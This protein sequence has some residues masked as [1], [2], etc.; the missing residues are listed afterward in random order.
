MLANAT[1]LRRAG[2]LL[3]A[4]AGSAGWT[5]GVFVDA[6]KVAKDAAIGASD[7]EL[8]DVEGYLMSQGWLRVDNETE[9][10]EGWFA[11]TRHGLDES[12]RK[13]PAEPKPYKPHD[14]VD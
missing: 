1:N 8:A 12:Q 11:L 13:A 2:L 4:L 10:G 6:R 7:K 3:R 14:R 5:M 9:R